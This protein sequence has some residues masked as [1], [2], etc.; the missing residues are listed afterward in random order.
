MK[1]ERQHNRT[2]GLAA[3]VQVG[4]RMVECIMRHQNKARAVIPVDLQVCATRSREPTPS[5]DKDTRRCVIANK[6]P[7]GALD[8]QPW[9]WTKKQPSVVMKLARLLFTWQNAVSRLDSHP[10]RHPSAIALHRSS[11][12]VDPCS[13]SHMHGHHPG[14]WAAEC[15]HWVAV[16]IG[17]KKHA[18]LI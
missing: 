8:G 10:G 7:N 1:S 2:S 15:T 5:G 16:D 3:S 13:V 4:G 9:C 14:R 6:R 18:M 11:C 12:R 17:R